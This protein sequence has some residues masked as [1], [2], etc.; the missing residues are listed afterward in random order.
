MDWLGKFLNLPSQFLHSSEGP[1]GGVIQGSAGE[2][3]TVVI[4]A[5]I[6]KA[7]KK[8]P[9]LRRHEMCVVCSD[10]THAIVQKATMI[11]GCQF[12]SVKTTIAEEYAL[13]VGDLERELDHASEDGL[14]TVAVVATT[15]TTSSCAF[16]PIDEIGRLCKLR[17]IGWLHIDAAY[18]GAYACL[19]EYREKFKG[20]EL[21]DSFCVNCHKKLLCPFDLAALYVADRNPLLDA[22]S[23]QPE[24]LRNSASDSGAV[25]DFEH[26]QMP[27]G[28]RFRSL[29]L[30]FVMRRFG[31]QGLK[32][33]VQNGV[34][35]AEHFAELVRRDDDLELVVEPS[36]SLVCFRWANRGEEDQQSLLDAIKATG[37]CFL[38][39]TKLEGRIA[40]RLAAGGIEQQESD[41]E[42]AY[43]VIKKCIASLS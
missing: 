2:S 35:L 22:L 42:G 26:W 37:D 39:H 11:L 20:L 40:I 9:L 14:T 31:T 6:I 21:A 8:S 41:I 16:D 23:L 36:L 25:V 34:K 15:G 13:N 12:R 10:Q 30:W 3:A 1:G 7:I 28:R 43:R 27:L 24:Y 17:E 38:I 4:L 19:E 5:A 29:K 18:G 32:F 33:H